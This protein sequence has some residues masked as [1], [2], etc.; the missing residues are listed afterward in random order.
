VSKG[1]DCLVD[2]L[3]QYL[4]C[5]YCS[6]IVMSLLRRPN[7]DEVAEHYGDYFDIN[8]MGLINRGEKYEVL[9]RDGLNYIVEVKDFNQKT[10]HAHLHFP[11][12]KTRFDFR[13]SLKDVYITDEGKYSREAGI[14]ALNTYDFEATANAKRSSQ[15]KK[16]IPAGTKSTYAANTK[17]DE[18]FFSKPRPSWAKKRRSGSD[19]SQQWDGAQSAQNSSDES[20]ADDKDT[21]EFSQA[22]KRQRLIDQL[23]SDVDNTTVVLADKVPQ[24]ALL[25]NF[26]QT[27]SSR[28]GEAKN[29][30]GLR[31]SDENKKTVS[32]AVPSI[33]KPDPMEIKKDSDPLR[34]GNN[35]NGTTS[36]ISTNNNSGSTTHVMNDA[37]N[38]TLNTHASTNASTLLKS[39]SSDRSR[40]YAQEN[41]GNTIDIP[42]DIKMLVDALELSYTVDETQKVIEVISAKSINL[43]RKSQV[44][45]L[46][47]LLQVRRNIDQSILEIINRNV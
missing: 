8:R 44:T 38:R 46:L 24:H 40:L 1:I 35:L 26:M 18:D 34:V 22:W 15:T 25:Q 47:K 2:L 36:N 30:K 37:H 41:K 27:G 19:S 9:C 5:W 13:G 16:T 45:L 4:V 3:H 42:D 21:P 31:Q 7:G 33:V 28:S 32:N 17:Y 6:Y 29:M 10:F 14:T 39:T 12:W 11:Q 20:S 23:Q 43:P